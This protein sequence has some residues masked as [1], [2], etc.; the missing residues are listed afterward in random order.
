M[1][2]TNG[3]GNSEFWG[4]L[5]DTFDRGLTVGEDWANKHI[6]LMGA[7]DKADTEA[8]Q[9]AEAEKLLTMLVAGGFIIWIIGKKWNPA[10]IY[11]YQDQ[12]AYKKRKK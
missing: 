1:S 4:W 3:N 9:K 5:A 8:L 2:E 10:P 7:S 12:K 6:E 11:T